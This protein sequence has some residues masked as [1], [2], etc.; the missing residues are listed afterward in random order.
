VKCRSSHGPRSASVVS[1][2]LQAGKHRNCFVQKG[3]IT[4]AASAQA[5]TWSDQPHDASGL[6]AGRRA[7][8]QEGITVCMHACLCYR[9][10]Q[11]LLT[12]ACAITCTSSYRSRSTSPRHC[13]TPPQPSHTVTSSSQQLNEA[14]GLYTCVLQ[15]AG[16]SNPSCCKVKTGC[17]GGNTHDSVQ[18]PQGIL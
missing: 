1:W 18:E 14:G 10:L 2:R 13:C 11:N 6:T 3:F 4:A 8:G 15:V 5:I 9:D 7:A 16:T 12:Y 17:T